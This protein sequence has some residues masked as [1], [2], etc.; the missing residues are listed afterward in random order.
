MERN[1]TGHAGGRDVAGVLDIVQEPQVHGLV[2]LAPERADQGVGHEVEHSGDG[3]KLILHIGVAGIAGGV[4]VP[5]RPAHG[6]EVQSRHDAVAG[7]DVGLLEGQAD[8][9]CPPGP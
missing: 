5:R 9:R 3:D 2:Q 4:V 6:H 8:F 7:D 1:D